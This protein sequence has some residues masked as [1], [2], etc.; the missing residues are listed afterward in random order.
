MIRHQYQAVF[1][2]LDGTLIDTAPDMG[3]ALN[4]QLVKHHKAPLSM[5]EIRPWV[6]HGAAALL[7]LGFGVL[8]NDQM[9]ATLRQ[10]YLNI[11]ADNLVIKSQ[12]FA[13]LGTLLTQL[14]CHSIHWGVVTN[15][16]EF[17]ALPLLEQL[18]LKDR[19][20]A[21][22]CGDT[23]KPA[24]PSPVPLFLACKQAGTIATQSI[25]VGDA[26]RDIQAANAAG[27]FS[28]AA[29]YG[30]VEQENNLQGWKADRIVNSPQELVTLL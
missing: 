19:A 22:V 4:L 30:Y 17:L 3:L 2:D 18:K 10:E 12:L 14:E 15:K 11:Y 25:Y 26:V 5:A 23:I 29:A 24:K 7:K 9:F 13:G 6:S 20:S 8:P 28:I 1:F 27:M 16:P 21:I